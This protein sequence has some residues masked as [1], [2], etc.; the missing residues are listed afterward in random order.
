MPSFTDL[1][2][3]ETDS[4]KRNWAEYSKSRG[5]EII[6]SC[7]CSFIKLYLQNLD[8]VLLGV[9]SLKH[10]VFLFIS[11]IALTSILFLIHNFYT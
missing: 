11:F 8:L 10:L 9:S 6:D 4:E 5:R 1:F 7:I 2:P 3:G